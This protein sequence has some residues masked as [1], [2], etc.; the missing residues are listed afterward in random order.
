MELGHTILSISD[1]NL[2][3]IDYQIPTGPNTY[4]R[5]SGAFSHDITAITKVNVAYMQVVYV[6]VTLFYKGKSGNRS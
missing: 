3:T 1:S 5:E 4:L 2:I 6:F